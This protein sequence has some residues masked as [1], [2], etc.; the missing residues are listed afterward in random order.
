[1][2]EVPTFAEEG[3]PNF[4]MSTWFA[5]FAPRGTPKE[6]V[7]QLNG[8]TRSLH[9]DPELKKRIES[10]FM[11]PLIMTQPQFAALV[12]ADA[13]KWERVVRESGL[14]LD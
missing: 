2:P 13:V 7:D 12:K 10:S 4:E 1:V 9:D 8:Y 3:F 5:L 14:K 6:I 11:D